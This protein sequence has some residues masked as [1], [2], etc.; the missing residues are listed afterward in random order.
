MMK[1]TVDQ[2]KD[3]LRLDKPV[4]LV[5]S[6]QNTIRMAHNVHAHPQ[7]VEAAHQL[8]EERN[9]NIHV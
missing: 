1:L 9:D 7:V 8:L 5:E 2:F 3:A 6:Q 4:V